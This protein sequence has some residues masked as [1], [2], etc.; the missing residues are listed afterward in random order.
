MKIIAFNTIAVISG[1]FVGSL[2]NFGIVALGPYVI[3]YPTGVDMSDV[4]SM[5]ENMNLLK[6]I[7]FLVPF[8]AHSLGTLAGAAFA[9]RTAASHPTALATVIGLFFLAGGIAMVSMV[10]GPP[11]FV[12]TD[13]LLAYLPMSIAGSY[14]G[15]PKRRPISPE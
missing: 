12:L 9:A 6:P 13:L 8:L 1:L 11:W 7:N 2:V 14:L 5:Q 15:R 4:E 10:G 3:P